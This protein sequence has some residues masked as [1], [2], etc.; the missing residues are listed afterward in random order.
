MDH[1]RYP[2]TTKIMK[3]HEKQK[4]EDQP[5]LTN[6][7]QTDLNRNTAQQQKKSRKGQ[8]KV[9]KIRRHNMMVHHTCFIAV[10][11][12]LICSMRGTSDELKSKS[13]PENLAA[14]HPREQ[15]NTPSLRLPSCPQRAIPVPSTPSASPSTFQRTRMGGWIVG[16]RVNN[17]Q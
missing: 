10:T 2:T 16:G 17:A 7:Q 15:R 14:D 11:P 9:N 4:I 5:T 13:P 12:I 8:K 3:K 6:I 1:T